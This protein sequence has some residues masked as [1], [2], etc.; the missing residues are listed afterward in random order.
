MSGVLLQMKNITKEFPGVKAL[1]N[2]N[3]SVRE[4]NIHALVG[5]NGAGKSTLMNVL[6]GIYPYGSYTG[7][8]L[9]NNEEC[10]FSGIKDSEA[11]GIAII[12]QELALI[13]FLSLAENMFLGNEC[14][15]HNV[16]NW[17]ETAQKTGEFMA[18]VGL[19]EN[20]E[21]LVKDISIGKQQLVEIAK[22]LAKKARLLI[23]DEPTAALN[24]ED[25]GRLLN[26]ILELKKEGITSILISHKLNEV[27]KAADEITILRDGSTI[28]TLTAGR[29]DI[30][31]ARIVKGMVDREF[32]DFY[33]RRKPQIGEVMLEISDW[34]VY[35]PVIDDKKVIDHVSMYVRKGEIVGIAG[36]MGAGRT[37]FAMSVF[38][39][40]YGRKISGTIK[41][42][43]RILPLK[44]V[45][46]AIKSG[47]AYVTE[48]RKAAGLILDDT[49]QH[50]ISLAS[51][52][53]M[54][55]LSVINENE[56]IHRCEEYVKKLNIKTSGL[57]QYT[58]NLSGG[59]QQKV[60][61]GKWIMTRPD[62]LILDEPTRGIDVGAKYEIYCLI[63]E[64]AL[65]QKS[66]IFISS[67]LPELL[68]ITDRI[69][70]MNE[71]RIVDEFSS[72]DATQEKIMHSIMREREPA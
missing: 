6:S 23:L 14:A 65:S 29:D 20:S 1:N 22:T 19:R 59:N 63:N 26:L 24:D 51:L 8:I 12:H 60:V 47:I 35:S 25:S 34:N 32:I 71:G 38:G 64:L 15:S 62:V 48:D 49:I 67:E 17:I 50:N 70:V 33:P 3:L 41:K 21:T 27:M 52:N 40:S 46:D 4:G 7:T 28:E 55:T 45:D 54:S 37:E 16:I 36:L 10:R 72:R 13:P 66:I 2:V 69:Y 43:S 56:E 44:T 39:R 68:G 11:R 61:L 53:Q 58:G 42:E 18:R 9:F 30:S 5:E 31:S 57:L